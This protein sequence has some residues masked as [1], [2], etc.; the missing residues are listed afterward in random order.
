MRVCVYVCVCVCVYVCVCVS[1][2]VCV[3]G[4][5]CVWPTPMLL[6][7]NDVMWCDMGPILLVKQVLYLLYYIVGIFQGP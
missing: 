4:C 5:V 2:S 6:I 7:A 1:V 3:G